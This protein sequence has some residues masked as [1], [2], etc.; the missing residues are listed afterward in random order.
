MV[1]DANH[2]AK[3][4]VF[5]VQ[6]VFDEDQVELPIM[7][8]GTITDASGRTLT[9]QVT[10]AFYNSLRHAKPMTIGLNCAL[11]PSDLR[12]YIAEMSRVSEVGVSAHPNAG[13]PNEL[14]EYDLEPED[15]AAHISEWADSGFLNI[16]GGCCGS[17][18]DHITAIA[19]SMAKKTPRAL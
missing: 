4:A 11:G 2:N 1:F 7:I 18:P 16:V 9:G 13:L 3:A 6:T 10:E 8:S 5:A 14:G 19:S 12:Q 15:M 17:S